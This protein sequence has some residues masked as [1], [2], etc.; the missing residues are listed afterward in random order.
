MF[1]SETVPST[2]PNYASQLRLQYR[3]FRDRFHG[4]AVPDAEADATDIALVENIR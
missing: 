2:A 1:P 3:A 4:V